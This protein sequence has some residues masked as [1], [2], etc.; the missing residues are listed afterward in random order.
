MAVLTKT[1]ME[2]KELSILRENHKLLLATLIAVMRDPKYS[3]IFRKKCHRLAKQLILFAKY[4][5]Q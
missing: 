1:F 2:R 3:P 4:K 5:D